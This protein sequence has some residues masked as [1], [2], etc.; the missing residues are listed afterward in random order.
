[1]VQST[2]L[3]QCFCIYTASAV[4]P[5]LPITQS[6]SP[7]MRFY[8]RYHQCQPSRRES[9][10]CHY[11]HVIVSLRDPAPVALRRKHHY[12]SANRFSTPFCTAFH[13]LLLSYFES[14]VVDFWGPKVH[15][16]AHHAIHCTSPLPLRSRRSRAGFHLGQATARTMG[17]LD[18]VN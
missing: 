2:V 18:P 7:F 13:C 5:S 11:S 12:A 14:I 4:N 17:S 3:I 6:N 8:N 9:A 15:T 1:M 10:Q 16:V